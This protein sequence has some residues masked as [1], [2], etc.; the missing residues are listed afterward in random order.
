MTILRTIKGRTKILLGSLALIGVAALLMPRDKVRSGEPFRDHW[1]HFNESDTVFVFIHGIFSDS[2]ACWTNT[3]HNVY[4]PELVKTD[5]RVDHPSVFLASFYTEIGSGSY[6]LRDCTK[7]VYQQ[8]NVPDSTSKKRPLDKRNIVFVTH[9]TGGIVA[10]Q[11][12]LEHPEAFKDKKVGLVLMASPS[13]GSR[14]GD[15][16]HGVAEASSHELGKILDTDNALLKDLDNRFRDMVDGRKIPT[17][18]G[19]EFIENHFIVRWSV[20]GPE[21]VVTE[22]TG[23]RYFGS[24]TRIADSDHFSI[25]KPDGPEHPSH[26][27]LV[28]FYRDKFLPAKIDS[29]QN[30]DL[31]E[32]ARDDL[33]KIQKIL[34]SEKVSQG[35]NPGAEGASRLTATGTLSR[36]DQATLKELNEHLQ[37]VLS[38]ANEPFTEDEKLVSEAAKIFRLVTTGRTEEM[39][40]VLADERFLKVYGTI[41]DSL[42]RRVELHSA[43]S[44]I[45]ARAGL[46]VKQWEL[47][48]TANRRYLDLNPLD[49]DVWMQLFRCH[50]EYAHALEAEGR[51]K[52]ALEQADEARRIL[53]RQNGNPLEFKFSGRV[54]PGGVPRGWIPITYAPGKHV[55]VEPVKEDGETALKITTDDGSISVNHPTRIDLKK[56]PV[57]TW[58]WRANVL[59]DA[60]DIRKSE[61]DDQACQLLLIVKMGR[62]LVI[63]NYGWD[64]N[65]PVETTA[66]RDMPPKKDPHRMLYFVVKKGK[67][68]PGQWASMT[69]NAYKDFRAVAAKEM[70]VTLSD[71]VPLT[72]YG[73]CVQANTQHSHGKSSGEFR[74]IRFGPTQSDVAQGP[75]KP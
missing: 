53:E 33:G 15:W 23:S 40:K 17:L 48:I 11:V 67:G 71:D 39:E 60:G 68:E 73:V 55:H 51:D 10:R 25:V 59:P 21:P 74:A 56:T 58:Q 24:P 75:G 54:G 2:R 14:Y 36:K 30:D 22:F 26:R 72:V 65:A 61:T 35:V 63:F 46:G 37:G 19:A 47:A 45:V 49:D 3:E 52:D 44:M 34:S 6:G 13:L 5:D 7:E 28:E 69:R 64:T 12:L 32:Q 18:L 57:V 27:S 62:E 38:R 42:K 1:N 9:S 4:W 66:V 29:K 31:Y 16:L 43:F 8:L 20:I 70:G 50:A 41:H